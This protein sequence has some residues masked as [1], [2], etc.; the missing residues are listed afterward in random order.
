MCWVDHTRTELQPHSVPLPPDLAICM[1][2]AR[3]RVDTQG[4]CLTIKN[5]RFALWR[6]EQW[7]VLML[8]SEHFSLQPRKGFEILCWVPSLTCLPPMS[9]MSMWCPARAQ[10]SQ[11]YPSTFAYHN[12]SKTGSSEDLGLSWVIWGMWLWSFYFQA[13]PIF[14]TF[15]IWFESKHGRSRERE[16]A[17]KQGRPGSINHMTDVRWD[18]K[19]M[20]AAA[21]SEVSHL[22]RPLM[23]FMCML[24][25]LRPFPI[26]LFFCFWLSLSTKTENR[27]GQEQGYGR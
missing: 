7:E 12:Q 18:T 1:V 23:P 5:S 13:Y 15:V 6:P 22:R 9:P 17:V 21:K 4:W 20:G 10:I 8:P 27:V 3:Q 24:N 11:E 26:F 14:Y 16:R 19:Q 2:S 25:A